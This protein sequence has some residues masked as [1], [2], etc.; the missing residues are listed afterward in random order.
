MARLE[1]RGGHDVED[2]GVV[3]L[4]QEVFA[5]FAGTGEVDDEGRAAAGDVLWRVEEVVDVRREGAAVDAAI[6]LAV[7]AGRRGD[8]MGLLIFSRRQTVAP[9]VGLELGGGLNGEED[10]AARIWRGKRNSAAKQDCG[11]Q[12][13]GESNAS[14]HSAYWMTPLPMLISFEAVAVA[15]QAGQA[16][17]E[18]AS[19]TESVYLPRGS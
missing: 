12:E 9:E 6:A 10:S 3:E 11:G 2:A 1:V 14:L 19:V 18:A 5:D 4:A 8:R 17:L 15:V 13:T 16:R 7:G